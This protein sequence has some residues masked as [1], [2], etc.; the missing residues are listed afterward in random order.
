M[1]VKYIINNYMVGAKLKSAPLHLLVSQTRI[2]NKSTEV[3]F[4]INDNQK[5]FLD[6]LF[7]RKGTIIGG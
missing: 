7:A 6:K 2:N 5:Q 3:V 4:N 1:T